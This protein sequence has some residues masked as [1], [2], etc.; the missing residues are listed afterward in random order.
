MPNLLSNC[1][2]FPGRVRVAAR[3]M[4]LVGVLIGTSLAFAASEEEILRPIEN[5]PKLPRVLLIGDSISIGYTL[6]VREGLKGKANVH[7]IP[8]NSTHTGNVLAHLDEWL[9]D[10]SWDVIHINVGL[11]DVKLRGAQRQISPEVYEK[12]LRAIIQRLQKTKATVI[13][14]TTTPIPD[15]TGKRNAGDE[16]IYNKI[17]E[18]VMADAGVSVDDLNAVA[19]KN[20]KAWQLPRDVHFTEAGYAALTEAVVASVTTALPG[21]A[22]TTRKAPTSQTR[23][24]N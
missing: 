14:A 10:G 12:N 8:A 4:L 15:Q 6:Q 23:P 19:S 7:R 16:V 17:A 22:A 20:L 1:V 5:D 24:A 13:W 2:R 9:G 11:H 3:L 21:G 18:K